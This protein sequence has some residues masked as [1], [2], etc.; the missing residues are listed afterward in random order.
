MQGDNPIIKSFI[1]LLAFHT[2][3]PEMHSKLVICSLI[4]ILENTLHIQ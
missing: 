3:L 1:F 2:D 4:G